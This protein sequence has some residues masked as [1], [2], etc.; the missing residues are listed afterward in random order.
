MKEEIWV[1][2]HSTIE[3]IVIF[4][5]ILLFLFIS[6]L[7]QGFIKKTKALMQGRRGPSVIQ[8]YKDLQ[9]WLSKSE[10]VSTRTS[11]I[12][13]FTP[14]VVFGA[15]ITAALLMPIIYPLISPGVESDF[16]WV[17]ANGELLLLIYI[18]ALARFFLILA[19]L[20]AASAFG[21]MGSARELFVSAL[22][23]PVFL[24]STIVFALSAES[25]NLFL[26]NKAAINFSWDWYTSAHLIGI[27]SCFIVLLAETGRIPLDNPDTHLELTMIHEGI[28]LEYSGRSLGLLHWS[29]WVKQ[30]LL[31]FLLTNLFIPIGVFSGITDALLIIVKIFIAACLLAMT[32]TLLCKIRLFRVPG[33]MGAAFCLAILAIAAHFMI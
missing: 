20:D 17:L 3:F 2:D 15:T 28:I 13:A 23:E 10:V 5:Q 22:T 27:V 7:L 26:I 16:S 18:L 29:L 9:K 32:E 30:M 12:F 19:G 31:I 8:P 1:L 6:P 4:V 14:Y 33:L 21:G 24:V 11:W 25:T